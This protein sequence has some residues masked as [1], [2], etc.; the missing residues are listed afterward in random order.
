R[1][2]ATGRSGADPEWAR[3]IHAHR[4]RRP[5][6]WSTEEVGTDP[7]RLPTLLAH[8]DPGDAI[9]VDEIGTWVGALLM[10]TDG[11]AQADDR[12]PADTDEIR[13]RADE[14]GAAVAG[15]PA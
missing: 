9:L 14:L 5:V 12:A 15:C 6:A 2:V 3:R 10:P 13:R 1:Y 4:I 8:A 11:S 7:Q